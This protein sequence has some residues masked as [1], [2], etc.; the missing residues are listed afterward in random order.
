M[1][2]GTYLLDCLT[3]LLACILPAYGLFLFAWRAR[4]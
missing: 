4:R 2:L 1:T 3:V